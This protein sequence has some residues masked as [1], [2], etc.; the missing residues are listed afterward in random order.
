MPPIRA[1]TPESNISLRINESQTV[2]GG[3]GKWEMKGEGGSGE[4]QGR[5]TSKK[6]CELQER[7]STSF[8]EQ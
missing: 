7:M 3:G 8:R 4:D 2:N 1:D 6:E 5:L